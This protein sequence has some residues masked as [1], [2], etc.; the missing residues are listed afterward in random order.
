[1]K[2][3]YCKIINKRPLTEMVMGDLFADWVER[4]LK[5][6]NEGHY[7]VG[8]EVQCKQG[9]ADFI[10]TPDLQMNKYKLKKISDLFGLNGESYAMVLSI[11]NNNAPRTEEYIVKKSG[12]DPRNIRKIISKMV[13]SGLVEITSSGAYKISKSWHLKKSELW[14]FELKLRDWKRA[15]YQGQQYKA[16]AS[17]V[18]LVFPESYRKTVLKNMQNISKKKFG[19]V[20]Y[21]N[22]IDE[23]TY[24]IKPRKIKP[25]SRQHYI[26]A[27]SRLAIDKL[28]KSKQ[29]DIKE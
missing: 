3:A 6:N 22:V 10:I 29:G 2:L 19:I 24:L 20:I 4:Q 27:L 12:K 5:D 8:R 23:F 1:M 25:L 9:I 14:A 7:Y 18:V 16:F 11:I 17:R 26:Y 13:D 21:N 28:N 15:V